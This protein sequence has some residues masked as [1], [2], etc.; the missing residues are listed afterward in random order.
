MSN[1]MY[2]TQM[3]FNEVLKNHEVV[4]VDFFATWC[5]PCKMLGPEIEKLAD[6]MKG[7]APV[8]KIDVD[9]EQALAFQYQIQ[10]IPTIL[11]FKNGQ[12]ID[13]TMGFQ[14]YPKLLQLLEKHLG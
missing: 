8:L 9:K 3:E 14:P 10:S 5:G 12:V 7:K 11:I 6:E 1:V 4:F 2:P 13:R